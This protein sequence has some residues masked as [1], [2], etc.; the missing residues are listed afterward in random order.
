MKEL[1]KKSVLKA[2]NGNE[3]IIE[4]FDFISGA[5]YMLKVLKDMGALK[6]KFDFIEMDEVAIY[7]QLKDET[8]EKIN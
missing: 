6:V 2:H 8:Y 3:K 7:K 5:S 4:T 1:V